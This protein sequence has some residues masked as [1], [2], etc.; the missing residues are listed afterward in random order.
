VKEGA[1][2]L[3]ERSRCLQ[4]TVLNYD[5]LAR[6]DQP[7]YGDRAV[8][9]KSTGVLIGSVGFVPCLDH[10]VQLPYFK[11]LYGKTDRPSADEPSADEPP[12]DGSPGD[13]SCRTVEFGL[14]FA[15][16][17][18]YRGQGLATEAARAMVD[19]AFRELKLK[20]VVATTSYENNASAAVMRRLGMR[21][22]K[23]PFQDPPWLQVVGI[24]EH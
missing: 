15:L 3:E 11:E 20:R 6:L 2:R 7:P 22:D 8:V 10:F 1:Q 17:T 23:N 12:P 9:L 24:L 14:F 5:Q 19:Y 13:G 21:I 18:A 16:S 4:W